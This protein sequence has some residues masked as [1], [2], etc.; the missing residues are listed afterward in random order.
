MYAKLARVEK[1]EQGEEQ[2]IYFITEN[3]GRHFGVKM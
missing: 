1:V 2:L 3:D